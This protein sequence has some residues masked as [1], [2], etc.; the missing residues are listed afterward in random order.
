M[1]VFST[2]HRLSQIFKTSMEIPF[3]S[4]SR[5][6]LFS[7]CHKGDGSWVDDFSHNRNLYYCALKYYYEYGFT[8]I[9]LGD[10]EELWKNRSFS[11]ICDIYGDISRLLHKFYAE[12]R[13][14][15]IYGNHDIVK[16]YPCFVEENLGKYYDSRTDRYE[17]LFEGIE[18]HEGLILKDTETQR[19]IFLVH[20]HQGDL[21]SDI[22][23]KVGRFLTR[24][25]WRRLEF[26]GLKDPTSAA[27]NY[28]KKRKVERKIVEWASANRQTVI[29]GHTHRPTCPG[30]GEV[31]YFNTGSCVH[32]D[33]ITCIEIVNAEISL[34]KWNVKTREDRTVYVDRELLAVPRKIR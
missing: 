23:W 6:V 3:D 21:V 29:A 30:E 20:G 32:P 9:D 4:S 14:Y 8:Y 15:M 18:V 22:F 12:K 24:Y 27:K 16:K 26:F 5:I 25:V 28:D 11:E 2:F 1:T 19:K 33:C 34:V 17:S 13:F 10:S 31:Q 7:D